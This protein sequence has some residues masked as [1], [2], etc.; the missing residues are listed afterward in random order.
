MGLLWENFIFSGSLGIILP[1]GI[2]NIFLYIQVFLVKA[3][4]NK[5]NGA[6]SDNNRKITTFS[7]FCAQ[8]FETHSRFRGFRF[9][10]HTWKNEI[11][12]L[13]YLE[14]FAHLR[15]QDT[16]EAVS[17]IQHAHL[18]VYWDLLYC[19]NILLSK[20][21]CWMKQ[22]TPTAGQASMQHIYTAF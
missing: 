9:A 3:F 7:Q 13:I 11:L 8:T 4:Q 2:L 1:Q 20:L 18:N 14:K 21:Y 10:N 19:A 12:K 6:F 15:W 5:Q 16:P 22:S 17:R